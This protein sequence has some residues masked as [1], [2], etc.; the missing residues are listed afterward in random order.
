MGN[1]LGSALKGFKQAMG[2]DK[3]IVLSDN[4]QQKKA[5][6]DDNVS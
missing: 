4:T 5:N 2:D 3:D 6:N 1:D